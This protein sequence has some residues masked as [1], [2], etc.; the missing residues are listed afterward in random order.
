MKMK[1]IISFILF[2]AILM[3]LTVPFVSASGETDTYTYVVDGVECTVDFTGSALDDAKRQFVAESLLGIREDDGD[4][5]YGLM[6]NLFGHKKTTETRS[7]FRHKIA[8]FAPRCA[9]DY[10]DITTCSRCDY[11]EQVFTK[12]EHVNCCP[13]E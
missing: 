4:T 3:S 1:K 7:V 6:C 2:A 9:I 10:Y 5:T 8:A 11:F 13:E 12:R